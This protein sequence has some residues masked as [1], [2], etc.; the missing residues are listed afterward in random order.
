LPGV[1]EILKGALMPSEDKPAAPEIEAEPVAPEIEADPVAPELEADP[2]A[3]AAD[4]VKSLKALAEAA[5]IDIRELY[6]LEVGLGNGEDPITLGQMK[7]RAKAS[8][9]LDAR[10]T[11]VTVKQQEFE[12]YVLRTQSEL[13]EAFA[14]AK[15]TPEMLQRGAVLHEQTLEREQ[16]ALWKA[17]PRLSDPEFRKQTHMD[18]VE[19]AAAYGISA[20]EVN[21]LADHRVYK[22]A[23]DFAAIRKQLAAANPGAKRTLKG[24][25]VG[26]GKAQNGTGGDVGLID[27][28][29]RSGLVHD[30][31]RAVASILGNIK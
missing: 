24:T 31:V 19:M 15:L 25:Q 20:N 13:R 12:N 10:E 16:A 21:N 26:S 3:P 5:G 6:A 28:A 18:V 11:D 8:I 9:D 30:Q 22:W 17:V 7:D 29:K 4:K 27:K 2:V 23:M 14:L 1:T